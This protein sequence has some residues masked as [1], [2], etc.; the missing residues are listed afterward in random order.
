ML[1]A[2]ALIAIVVAAISF[3]VVDVSTSAANGCLDARTVCGEER[4]V[5]PIAVVCAAIGALALLGGIV[6]AILWLVQTVSQHQTAR[7]TDV[8]YS[9]GPSARVRDDEEDDLTGA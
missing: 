8:D 7:H 3:A 5:P 6:P 2:I 1:G 4:T 9:Q